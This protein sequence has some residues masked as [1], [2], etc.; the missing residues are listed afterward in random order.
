MIKFGISAVNLLEEKE[1]VEFPEEVV[2]QAFGAADYRC[3]CLKLEHGHKYNSLCM[4]QVDWNKRGQP[5]EKGW[6]ADFI[7][8]PEKGGKPVIENCEILCWD[9][10]TKKHNNE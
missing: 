5:D 6:Q 9:C 2:K 1:M 10:Y 4:H 3:E 7:V 8:P